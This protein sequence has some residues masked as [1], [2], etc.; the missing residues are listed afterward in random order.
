MNLY[1]VVFILDGVEFTA[2]TIEAI[3]DLAVEQFL[4]VFYPHRFP[5][6]FTRYERII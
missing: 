5:R 6:I 2:I 4:D 3:N 1:R